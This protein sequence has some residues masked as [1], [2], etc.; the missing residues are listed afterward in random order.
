[1]ASLGPFAEI[2]RIQNE[3]NRLIENLLELRT[4]GSEAGGDWLPNSDVYETEQ[5]LVVTFEV[6]G[7]EPDN[8]TIAI[9]GNSL[10]LR[11]DKRRR[12]PSPGTQFHCMERGFGRF[13]RVV[14]IT[15]PVNTH[16][17]A[18]V[19]TEGVLRV[20]FP[21]VPNRRGEEVP[22]SIKDSA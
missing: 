13:K 10:V 14:H 6:P 8:V 3:I 21:K 12:D 20:T 9:N 17:A 2:S 15:T 7:V 5:E 16:A 18:A 22:I 4:P 1:M 11:G 19:L